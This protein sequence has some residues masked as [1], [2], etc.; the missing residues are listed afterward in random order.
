MPLQRT[1]EA[2]TACSAPLL[3]SVSGPEFGPGDLGGQVGCDC[4]PC[5]GANSRIRGSHHR[6]V[7][8]DAWWSDLVRRKRRPELAH[9]LG[10][11]PQFVIRFHEDD[12]GAGPILEPCERNFDREQLRQG[13]ERGV[14]PPV[15]PEEREANGHVSRDSVARRPVVLRTPFADE[16]L[17]VGCDQEQRHTLDSDDA[18]VLRDHP[19]ELGRSEPAGVQPLQVC[20]GR[21]TGDGATLSDVDGN[22]VVD[23]LLQQLLQRR[24]ADTV[25]SP[26]VL[27]ATS[28]VPSPASAIAH[29]CPSTTEPLAAMWNGSD[30]LVGSP[31]PVVTR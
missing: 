17:G 29:S 21:P 15:R 16:W 30:A 10:Q 6:Q 31:A 28:S 12:Q 8:G 14:I 20:V 9:G 4:L 11:L 23:E 3:R 27:R 24:N 13:A 25:D 7:I 2:T 22:A 1:E 5:A 26:C 19:G 18:V